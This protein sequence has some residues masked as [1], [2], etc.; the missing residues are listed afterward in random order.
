MKSPIGVRATGERFGARNTGLIRSLGHTAILAEVFQTGVDLELVIKVVHDFAVDA[1]AAFERRGRNKTVVELRPIDAVKLR[2]LVEKVDETEWHNIDPGCTPVE[3]FVKPEVD[4]GL[5]E[6]HRTVQLVIGIVG[7][8]AVLELNLSVEDDVIGDLIGRQEHDAPGI[9]TVFPTFRRL[10][11][12]KFQFA[13]GSDAQD[14]LAPVT[15]T[16]KGLT[17]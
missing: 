14:C 17:R 10:L 3:V 6:F 2:R 4:I 5:L 13:V 7:D 16:K 15:E 11:P 9:E 12:A 1:G 8:T